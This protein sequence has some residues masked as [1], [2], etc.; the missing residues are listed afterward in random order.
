L[1]VLLESPII[2]TMFTPTPHDIAPHPLFTATGPAN[3][4]PLVLLHGVLRGWRDFAPLWPA[5][6]PRWQVVC[7]D[8]RGHGSSGR[9]PGRYHVLDY[10]GDAVELVRRL[11]EPV[12][13]YGHSLGALVSAYVAANLPDRVRAIVLED[14][15][16]TSFLRDVRSS[17]WHVIWAQMR[18]LAGRSESVRCVAQSLAEV[19]VPSGAG[20]KRLGDLRD[21]TSI[22]FSARC[23]IDLDPAVFDPL[24]ES[25]WLDGFDVDAIFSAVRCPV[26]FL[27]GEEP[28]GGMLGRAEA[29]RLAGLMA[30]ADVVDVPGAGH[31][32]HWQATE[33]T[34]RLV[35]GFLESL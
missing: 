31:L 32:I 1:T 34:T 33:V 14:P 23:L 4:P 15:P 6:V 24:L 7:V 35:L 17:S 26:L 5:L 25:R 28:F 16:A 29:L 9:T 18:V 10:A 20:E 12:V 27:R 3:G 11:S 2:A 8:Q 19:R 22:R 13:L 30:D 21:A